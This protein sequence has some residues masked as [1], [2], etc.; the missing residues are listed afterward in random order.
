M[1]GCLRVC[2]ECPHEGA[3]GGARPRRRGAV[4]HPMGRFP[5]R[6]PGTGMVGG[7]N[8]GGEWWVVVGGSQVT[9]QTPGAFLRIQ[10]R[11]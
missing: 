3:D 6:L 4:P 10:V 5:D 9:V 8:L 11:W 7:R 1:C 2:G